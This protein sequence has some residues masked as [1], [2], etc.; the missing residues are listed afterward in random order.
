MTHHYQHH[1]GSASQSQGLQ[2]VNADGTTLCQ[3]YKRS[4]EACSKVLH[5]RARARAHGA[6]KDG[7]QGVSQ[8]LFV[9]THNLSHW[10]SGVFDAKPGGEG[11]APRARGPSPATAFPLPVSTTLDKSFSAYRSSCHGQASTC[12]G[13]RAER[14]L[15]LG[16]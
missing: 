11:R 12:A 5:P 6:S 1:Q 3:L 7:I 2:I 16:L 15:T 8:N 14:Q 13:H 9:M 10:S 4:M